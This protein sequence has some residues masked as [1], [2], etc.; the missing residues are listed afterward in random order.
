MASVVTAPLAMSQKGL[1]KM[2]SWDGES[3]REKRKETM[4]SSRDSELSEPGDDPE[5]NGRSGTQSAGKVKLAAMKQR[6]PSWDEMREGVDAGLGAASTALEVTKSG[7]EGAAGVTKSGLRASSMAVKT[8]VAAPGV[9]AHAAHD[10]MGSAQH[11]ISHRLHVQLDKV[12]ETM[13]A[14]PTKWKFI[15][16]FGALIILV[17]GLTVLIIVPFAFSVLLA[18]WTM[19]VVRLAPQQD[20]DPTSLVSEAADL[21]ELNLAEARIKHQI[22]ELGL[23][24][25]LQNNDDQMAPLVVDLRK[26][27]AARDAMIVKLRADAR[28]AQEGAQ[29]DDIAAFQNPIDE[30]PREVVVVS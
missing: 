7:V 10:V 19:L 16:A 17:L 5:V 26:V 15:W 28:Q 22:F 13:A 23:A 1:M 14:L 18:L 6:T 21:A 20:E 11:G 8:G 2:G 25:G 3:E 9:L 30:L 29:E 24:K 27:Q 12:A 4:T